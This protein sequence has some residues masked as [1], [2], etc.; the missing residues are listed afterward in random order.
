[1]NEF[2]ISIKTFLDGDKLF[3]QALAEN[4][5]KTGQHLI[6]GESSEYLEDAIKNLGKE[7]NR[8]LRI[9]GALNVKEFESKFE[10][11]KK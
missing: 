2:K 11:R 3:F 9:K 8:I 1:M 4:N 10:T 5:E 6:W 7:M